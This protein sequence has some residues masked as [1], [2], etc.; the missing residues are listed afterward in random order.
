[1]LDALYSIYLRHPAIEK[2]TRKDVTGK[3]YWALRGER[4][5]GNAFVRDALEKGAAH[6]V[7]SDPRW[8]GHPRVTVVKDTLKTLQELA[9]HHRRQ[10]GVKV[11]AVTGSNGKTTT[12]ELMAAVLK[13]QFRVIATEGNLNNHIGVPLTL[14]RI[15]PE[16]EIAVVEMGINHFGEMEELC[17]I[18]EPDFGY[19][20]SFGE[21]H[22]EF[23]GDLDGVIKA[24]TV[25][26]HYLRQ[27]NGMAFVNFDDPVQEKHTAGM[28]RYGFSYRQHPSAAVQLSKKSRFPFNTVSYKHTDIPSRLF[29]EFHFANIGA[30]ITAGDYFGLS[31][32]Q[33][34]EGISGYVPQNNRSQLIRLDNGVQVI[35]DAYNANPTSMR[36]AI[37][38]LA[39]MPGKKTAVLGDMFELGEK[40]PEKHAA[41][42]RLL[43]EKQIPAYLI[44]KIFSGVPA[45]EYVLGKFPDAESFKKAVDIKNFHDTTILIKASR[46]M[47]LE[48]IL[49]DE[50][51]G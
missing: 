44:G 12:K 38:G 23:F 3:I 39:L 43:K 26:Y 36:A 21:A 10:S 5:D 33:I 45:N 51:A 1:M 49:G 30:A 17:A 46:G 14:L 29:G 35:L 41:I 13:R 25:L 22:L 31:P 11:I 32:E 20:T 37:E 48:R 4:F 27:H 16:T 9:R 24:K 2:D 18:A 34:R 7:S 42:V 19:I 40:A 8:Q 47:A 6:A 15:R 28:Q 50:F